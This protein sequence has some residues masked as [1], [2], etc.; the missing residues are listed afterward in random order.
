MAV[1]E[2]PR[3]GLCRIVTEPGDGLARA[4]AA[5][6]FAA[7]FLL[8]GSASLHAD[9]VENFYKGRTVPFVV[10][11]T[12]GGAYDL[13]ARVLAR[14]LSKHLPGRPSFVVQ[15]MPGAGSLKAANYLYGVAAQDG[16]AIGMIGRGLAME[17]LLGEARYDSRK[18]A[19][20][21][22]ITRETSVCATWVTAPVKR[23]ADMFTQELTV[24]G[25]G[26]GS[27]PDVFALMLRN[28]F[29]ARIKLVSGYPG[30]AEI[31]LAM[32][33]GEVHGRCGWSWSSIKSTKAAWLRDK[34]LNL[35][36][37]LALE[38]ESAL[39]DIP[40]VL[41]LA[42]TKEQTDIL[43]LVLGRQSMARPVLAP[44]GTPD[45]RKQALRNA[46]DATMADSDFTA[47]VAK[48]DLEI[49]PVTGAEIDRLLAELYRTP[50]DVI[51][52][53]SRAIK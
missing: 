31:N 17:P 13:Y 11:Y 1:V 18:F 42:K 35:L 28:A 51:D 25:E 50:R 46:F 37:Q 22:S 23:L 38:K 27:D 5:A 40:S 3:H 6:S 52:K 10:G 12:A 47:D 9:P 29:G 15:N 14:H 44:P 33:R 4:L 30:G 48:A 7:F 21:G 2:P 53:A 32:E 19:W 8:F 39:A 45:E 34:K 16:S 20:I 41:E 36:L 24:G 43:K 49:S 26:S